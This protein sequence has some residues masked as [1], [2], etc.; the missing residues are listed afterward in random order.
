MQPPYTALMKIPFVFKTA[1]AMVLLLLVAFAY[2]YND[3]GMSTSKPDS[4]VP[5]DGLIFLLAGAAIV[6]G[7]IK[8]YKE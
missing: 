1:L 3:S 2:S 5:L 6:Y 8:L 7:A 4:T